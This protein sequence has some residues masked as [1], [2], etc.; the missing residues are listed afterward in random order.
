MAWKVA[1]SSLGRAI[2]MYAMVLMTHRTESARVM[3]RSA[4]SLQEERWQGR[5]AG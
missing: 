2:R 1:L 5:R 4:R 3:V